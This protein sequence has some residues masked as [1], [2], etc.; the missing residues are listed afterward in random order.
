MAKQK[1]HRA[2]KPNDS[3]GTVNDG[4]LYRGNYRDEVYVEED[5]E[6][7]VEAKDPSNEATPE[8]ENE[9]SFAVAPE[10]SETD[11]KKRYDDL[12]RHYDS[13]LDEWKKEKDELSNTQQVGRESGLSASQLPKTPEELREFQAK[14]PDVYAI[15]ETISTLRADDKLQEMKSEIQHLKGR[16]KEL[17]VKSAYKELLSTHPDFP[18]LKKDGKF[19]EWLDKQPTSISD[20]IYKNNQDARWASRVL[21]LYKAD[22]GIPKQRKKSRDSDPAL[23]ITK[24]SAKNVVSEVSGNKKIWKASE[25]GKMKSWQFEKLE[26]ELDAARSEGRINFNA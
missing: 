4:G 1:G 7:T 10:E 20:G 6:T 19:L 9:Q 14:Y 13:R 11:Y 26:T 12:K 16:E 18:A 5:D 8:Q 2:N 17:E 22:M 15:V 3:F 23:G 21:D 25:I 24:A